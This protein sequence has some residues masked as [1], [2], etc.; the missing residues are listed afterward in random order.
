MP[1]AKTLLRVNFNL[2]ILTVTVHIRLMPVAIQSAT[3]DADSIFGGD[4]AFLDSLTSQS[5][6][7]IKRQQ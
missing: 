6:F 4:Q 3:G 5:C 1:N 7:L 2:A